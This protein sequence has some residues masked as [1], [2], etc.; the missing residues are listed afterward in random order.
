M[1]N[2]YFFDIANTETVEIIKV[3]ATG[4]ETAL[5]VLCDNYGTEYVTENIIPI[6]KD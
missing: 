5:E 1:T 6:E 3:Q 2:F 4:L